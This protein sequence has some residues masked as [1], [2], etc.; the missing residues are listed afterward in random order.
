MVTP[1]DAVFITMSEPELFLIL[2]SSVTILY[3]SLA[4]KQTAY[5]SIGYL[6]P[7]VYDLKLI[8]APLRPRASD[9][10]AY[11]FTDEDWFPEGLD[12]TAVE[13]SCLEPA[14]ITVE[15]GIVPLL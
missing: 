6:V 9:I 11:T 7:T 8:S 4:E 10:A 3:P 15:G 2:N 1:L 12:D 14:P 13:F 5:S